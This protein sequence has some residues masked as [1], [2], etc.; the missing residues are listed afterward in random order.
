MSNTIFYKKGYKYQLVKDYKV[1][2]TI[3]SLTSF[4]IKNEFV[5]LE[6]V[7]QNTGVLIIKSGYAWN[8]VSG[9]TIDDTTNIRGSLIHDAI[10]Q[11]IREGLLDISY[12]KQIDK[13]LITCCKEDNMGV[14]RRNY[15]YIAVRVFGKFTFN[16]KKVF[17]APILEG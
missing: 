12:R 5:Q 14:I 9:P 13:I 7:D 3:D 4:L 16:K 15:Y 6:Y 8:G 11:L 1:N 2:V 17:T 10:Y